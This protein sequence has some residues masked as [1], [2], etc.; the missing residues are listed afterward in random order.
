MRRPAF[1]A[2]LGP[3]KLVWA[4][5]GSL[6]GLILGLASLTRPRW[7]EGTLVFEGGRGFARLHRRLGYTAITMGQVIVANEPLRGA[8]RA[9]E[10]AHVR[11]WTTGGPIFAALYHLEGLREML[12]GR[13][14]YGD[15][16]FERRAT[17]AEVA[18][19]AEGPNPTENIAS[20]S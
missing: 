5:P 1:R 9:H 12:R 13:R 15:N 14:Y 3:L 20:R 11:Q 8:L 2:L 7:D 6:V 10:R 18:Y 4:A 19:S 17:A 16:W